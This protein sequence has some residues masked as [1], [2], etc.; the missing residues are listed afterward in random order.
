VIKYQEPAITDPLTLEIGDQ[1][2]CH[3][4][5]PARMQLLTGAAADGEHGIDTLWLTVRNNPADTQRVYDQPVPHGSVALLLDD[6]LLDGGR[7]RVLPL[8]RVWAR[9]RIV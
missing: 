9:R 2:G 8:P 3:D 6:L 7:W 4:V 1:V 5:S